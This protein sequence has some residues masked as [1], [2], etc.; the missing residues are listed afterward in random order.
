VTWLW[1]IGRAV[2]GLYFVISG[3]QHFTQFQNM[4]EYS[5]HKGI[6][7]PGLAVVITGLML[8][9][10]GLSVLTGY[11]VAVGLLLLAIFLTLAAF[12]MHNFWTVEDPAMKMGEMSQF[13]KNLGLASASLMLLAIAHWSWT[14]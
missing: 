8:L 11:A 10:G 3:I 2:F 14:T 4:K 5:S 13:M 9:A 7:A 6:P 1:L 12:F